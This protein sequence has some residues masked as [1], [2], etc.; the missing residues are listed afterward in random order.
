M[1]LAVAIFP[2]IGE[3]FLPNFDEGFLN[4]TFT[5][6]AGRTIDMVKEEVAAIE[7]AIL[8]VPGVAGVSSQA[9]DQGDTDISSLITG[10]GK[11]V[12]VM[13]VRLSPRINEV[14]PAL[15]SPMKF[16]RSCLMLM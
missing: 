11:N 1:L 6:P 10:T 13:S 7:G 2:T 9:G 4:L 5:L 8:A 3:E 15:R 14:V 16:G 12:V